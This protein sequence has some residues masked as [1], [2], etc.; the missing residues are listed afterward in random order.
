MKMLIFCDRLRSATSIIDKN[1]AV[2]FSDGHVRIDPQ[3]IRVISDIKALV[4]TSLQLNAYS[5]YTL[6][7]I[8]SVISDIKTLVFTVKRFLWSPFKKF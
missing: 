8:I 5:V 2:I 6:Q 4:F 1:F 3:I 7:L